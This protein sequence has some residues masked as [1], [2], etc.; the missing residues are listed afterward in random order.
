MKKRTAMTYPESTGNPHFDHGELVWRDEFSGRF[1]PPPD[2]YCEQF[3]DKWRL[4]LE[5]P[6]GGFG[7]NEGLGV[8]M[9]DDSIRRLVYEWTGEYLEPHTERDLREPRVHREISEVVPIELIRGKKC[10][11]AGCGMGRWT[12]VMQFMGASEVLSVDVS[13]HSLKSVRRFNEKVLGAD[14]TQLSAQHP[15]LT[16]QFDFA[17]L[18]GV[19]HHTHDPRSTFMNVAATVK[20]GGAMYLMVYDPGGEYNTPLINHYRKVFSAL[21]KAEDRLAFAA[22]VADRRW[23]PHIPLKEKL[24][25]VMRNVLSRPKRP[26]IR[27][28][29][30]MMPWYN[31]TIPIDVAKRWMKQAGFQSVNILNPENRGQ[32]NRHYLGTD[33]R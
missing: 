2:D 1:A 18:W 3:D 7:F 14:L 20:S 6:T 11:D 9:D 19:A 8:Q 10:I 29:D 15:E 23:H 12:R 31:W 17:N 27:I 30:I 33:K 21:Q 13:E 5:D 25:N 32:A 22:A 4:V 28:L 26:K 24:K 16:G